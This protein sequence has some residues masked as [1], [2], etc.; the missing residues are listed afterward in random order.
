M[1]FEVADFM[2]LSQIETLASAVHLSK[3]IF[4]DAFRGRPRSL[5]EFM[6]DFD[7]SGAKQMSIATEEGGFNWSAALGLSAA[8]F[9]SLG[10][11]TAVIGTTA[12]LVK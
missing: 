7:M 11:W 4:V 2:G 10:F 9:V 1:I 3:Q 5:E 12:A 8:L 6:R